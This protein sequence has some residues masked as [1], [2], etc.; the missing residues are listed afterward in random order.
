MCGEGRYYV[1]IDEIQYVDGFEDLVNSLKNAAGL[2][3][4]KEEIQAALAH[5]GLPENIRGEMLT[6][7]QFAQL[8][9]ELE[10]H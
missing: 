9:G 5:M 1:M 10:K 3:Y 8:T 4:T 7:E 6:L 2:S